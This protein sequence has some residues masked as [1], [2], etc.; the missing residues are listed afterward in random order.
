MC[1]YFQGT[2]VFVEVMDFDV[3]ILSSDLVDVFAVDVVIPLGP[4]FTDI[5]TYNGSYGIGQL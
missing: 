1:C 2:Q 4:S 3:A 5:Q